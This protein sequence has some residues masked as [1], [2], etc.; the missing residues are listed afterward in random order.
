MDIKKNYIEIH[1]QV[2]DIFDYLGRRVG[3][4]EVK[5]DHLAKILSYLI[6]ANSEKYNTTIDK[7]CLLCGIM[8]RYI[9]ENYLKPIEAWGFIFVYENQHTKMWK[10]VGIPH[11]EPIPIITEEDILKN[12]YEVY[13]KNCKEADEEA[14]PYDE[15]RKNK[16]K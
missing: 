3:E 5:G 4:G 8:A 10:W 16:E 12:R 14:V 7:L 13:V 11:E 15:W 2:V 1:K 6:S 9:R